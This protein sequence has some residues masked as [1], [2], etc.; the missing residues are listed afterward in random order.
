MVIPLFQSG[1]FDKGIPVAYFGKFK[2]P[3]I[4]ENAVFTDDTIKNI[5]INQIIHKGFKLLMSGTSHN[6]D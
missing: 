2:L 1:Y 4:S 6:Y 3:L 5:T